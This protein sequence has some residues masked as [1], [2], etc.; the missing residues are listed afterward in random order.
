MPAQPYLGQII[1][2]PYDFAPA[3]WAFCNGTLLSIAQND[4]LFTLIGTTYGGDGVN[5]FA[6][7]DLRGRFHVHVGQ[8]VQSSF[9]LAQ[10]GGVEQ[11]SLNTGQIPAHIHLPLANSAYST[12]PTPAD[13]VWGNAPLAQFSD[14]SSNV[15]MNPAALAASGGSQPHNNL[16]PYLAINFVIALIGIFPTPP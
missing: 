6:L 15:Q 4:A 2:V 7:P 1:M 8:G 16:P 9:V 3:G 10:T 5:T 14:Q 13:N 11:V 12:S